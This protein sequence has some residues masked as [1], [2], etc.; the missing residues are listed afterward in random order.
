V[1]IIDETEAQK[2][3]NAFAK[4]KLHSLSFVVSVWHYS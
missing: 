4:H 1:V 2:R 3:D